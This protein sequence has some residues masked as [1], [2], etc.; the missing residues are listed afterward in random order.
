MGVTRVAIVGAGV[1]G[2]ATAWALTQ[3]GADVTLFEQFGLDHERGS[4]HGRTRIVRL[5]YP[6]AGWVRL[7][8]EAMDAWRELEAESGTKLIDLYGIVELVS[9]RELASAAGLDALGIDYS[10]LDAGAARALGAVLPDGWSALLQPEAGVVRSDLARGAFLDLAR[11]R[12]AR[13]ETGRRIQSFDDVDADVVVLTTGPWI[14]ELVPDVPVQVTRETL[15]YFRREGAPAP[16]VVELDEITR[17]HG[18]YSLYDPAHGLKAGV[19]HGGPE[20]DPNLAGA[21]DP[22]SVA[23]VS[24]WVRQRFPDVDPTPIDPQTCLY[25]STVDGSFVLERRGRVV[26]GSA[27]SGHGFKFAP[28][29]GRRL[30]ALALR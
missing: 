12:G 23:R 21:P 15:A 28:V 22:A 17:G 24:E 26:V 25:T 18:M 29:V 14:R 9:S 13:V 1:M 27:C 4:S 30:A 3:R 6:D 20:A 19:H 10:W 8:R 16:A 2:C 5:S 11:S 7:A